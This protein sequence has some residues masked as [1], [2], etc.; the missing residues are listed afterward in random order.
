[1]NTSLREVL[2]EIESVK[3]DAVMNAHSG[4]NSFLS[5][6]QEE[7]SIRRLIALLA[8][9]VSARQEVFQRLMSLIDKNDDLNYAHPYDIALSV[10]LY[11][12][13]Q[14]DINLASD[15]AKQIA[16][17]NDLSW[18]RRLA[19]KILSEMIRDTPS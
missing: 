1:M 12:L 8:K 3:F 11:A 5:T 9:D 10:Y 18:A 17:R 4:F 2:N 13:E 14:A 7:A 19:Q 15:A 6:L 16:Q